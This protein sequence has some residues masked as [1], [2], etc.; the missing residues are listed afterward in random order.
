M[1]DYQGLLEHLRNAAANSDWNACRSAL[2]PLVSLI[3]TAHV[4][5]L[6][7]SLFTVFFNQSKIDLSNNSIEFT[8]TRPTQ[9]KELID[10]SQKMLPVIVEDFTPGVGNFT[11]SM[12]SI[13]KLKDLEVY[14][15][16]YLDNIINA[17]SNAIMAI[18]A[19][20]WGR[21]NPDLWNRAS[22]PKTRNDEFIPLKDFSRNTEKIVLGKTLWHKLA[23]DIELILSR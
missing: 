16:Q 9:L 18:L 21:Q 7:S 1:D 14:S 19:N 11:N 6:L 4:T 13:A 12:L 2:K 10:F 15:E 22:E 20:H 3:S 23:G 8:A 5:E 17:F